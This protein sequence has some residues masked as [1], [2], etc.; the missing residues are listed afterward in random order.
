MLPAAQNRLPPLFPT[1]H[2]LAA[3]VFISHTLSDALSHSPPHSRHCVHSP[4]VSKLKNCDSSVN[5]NQSIQALA[6]HVSG[7][8]YGRGLSWMMVS[9]FYTSSSI[10]AAC[11]SQSCSL[12]TYFSASCESHHG[13]ILPFS[14]IQWLQAVS[15]SNSC[16]FKTQ[17]RDFDEINWK[18]YFIVTLIIKPYCVVYYQFSSAKYEAVL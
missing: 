4:F 16:P 2:V 8:I 13:R 11:S 7:C 18:R 5:M 3:S 14:R 17:T 12:R 6:I 10:F 9:P 15:I 1:N